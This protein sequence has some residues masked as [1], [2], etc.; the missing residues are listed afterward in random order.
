MKN[1]IHIFF[2]LAASLINS[3]SGF[4]QVEVKIYLNKNQEKCSR[5]KAE[6]YRLITVDETGKPIGNVKDYY[7][8]GE[9]YWEGTYLLHDIKNI[10]NSIKEGQYKTFYKNENKKEEGRYV[11]NKLMGVIITWYESGDK[12]G[13]YH[14][15]NGTLNGKFIKWHTNGIKSVEMIY[16]NGEIEGVANWWYENGQKKRQATFK[17]GKKEGI[18]VEWYENGVKSKSSDLSNDLLNGNSITWYSNS[19]IKTEGIYI[20]GKPVGGFIIEYDEFNN[21]EKVFRENFDSDDNLNN[22]PLFK[23][24]NYFESE[25]LIDK[26]LSMK[27]KSTKGFRQLIPIPLDVYNDFVIKT[28]TVYFKGSLK[29]SYG[30]IW[31][32]KDEDNYCYFSLFSAGRF[33]IGE[34]KEGIKFK[35]VDQKT[36]S[37]INHPDYSGSKNT[38]KVLRSG[39]ELHFSINGTLVHT[40][41]FF[42]FRGDKIGFYISSEIKEVIFNYLYV[43]QDI[44]KVSLPVQSVSH[45]SNSDKKESERVII[46]TVVSPKIV[47]DVDKNIPLADVQQI[48]TYALIIGNEDYQSRQKGL[49]KEQ[50]V[51]Y[52][53]NDALIFAQYCEKTLG[54]PKRQIK[55]IIDAT[56]AEINQGLAWMNNLSNIEGGNAKLIFYYSGHGL[57]DEQT[58]DAYIIPIDVSGTNLKYAIK[59]DNIYSQLTEYPAR[60]VTVLFDACFSGGARNKQLVAMKG[61]KIKPKQGSLSGNLVVFASSQG[62]ESSAVYREKQHGYFTYYLLKKIKESEGQVDLENLFNYIYQ[63]VRKETG[64]EGKIQTPQ[65]NYSP[66]VENEWKYWRLD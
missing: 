20:E 44:P 61:V 14:F 35:Y 49:S 39:D 66:E 62:N 48:N 60:Q 22:W 42:S 13:E 15:E 2:I 25:I 40:Q 21:K 5:S 1:G 19:K 31:G 18:L 51:D 24:D 43:K 55:L 16:V 34:Y 58:K 3:L 47:V 28:S 56:S 30:L 45:S 37:S 7:I 38:L 27:S 12:S 50:N 52:A 41:D 46:P 54:I 53:E 64:L 32:Y 8:T 59:V 17:N 65:I 10:N 36:S 57:P 9:L 23:N 33:K 4:S 11:D 26:G 6:F 29:K 63:S